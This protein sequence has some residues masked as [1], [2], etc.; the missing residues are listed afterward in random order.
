MDLKEHNEQHYQDI[1]EL[2]EA[3][4]LLESPGEALNFFKDLC[5]PD[6]LHSLAERWKICKLLAEKNLSYRE[7]NKLTAASLGLI[8]RVARFLKDEPYHGYQNML[9]K[10]KNKR[11]K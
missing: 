11:Q 1:N 8:T 2:C 7:L 10:I 5:T 9:K 6:E 3:I 4:I